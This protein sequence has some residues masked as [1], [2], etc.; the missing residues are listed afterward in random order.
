MQSGRH[1]HAKEPISD[2]LK[3]YS[4]TNKSATKKLTIPSF[5]IIY[6]TSQNIDL[7]D[8]KK[9]NKHF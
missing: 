1:T 4:K 8:S 9:S 2:I 5:Y 6:K 3:S 7:S